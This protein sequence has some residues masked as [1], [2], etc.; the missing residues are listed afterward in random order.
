MTG[1]DER[2]A[3]P[4]DPGA[5][6]GA[7]AREAVLLGGFVL[8]LIAGIVTVLVPELQE[9]REGEGQSGTKPPSGEN[10]APE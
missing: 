4:A 6:R 1:S 3:E 5:I 9:A 7:G 2:A 10:A 8:L